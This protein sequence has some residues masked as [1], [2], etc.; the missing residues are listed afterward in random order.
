MTTPLV[1]LA[2]LIGPYLF[3]GH[4]QT[5][6]AGHPT[7]PQTRAA[8]GIATMFIFTGIGHFAATETMTQIRVPL[9]NRRQNISR[10]MSV[11]NRR[12]TAPEE[13]KRPAIEKAP[14]QAGCIAVGTTKAAYVRTQ[15]SAILL[16][17]ATNTTRPTMAA[18]RNG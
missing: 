16:F 5:H 9:G 8:I 15:I 4:V 2:L 10:P 11:G 13:L 7:S 3:L 18:R 17:D 14:Y 6:L 12:T 1:M